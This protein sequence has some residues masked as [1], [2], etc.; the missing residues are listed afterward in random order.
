MNEPIQLNDVHSQLNLTPVLRLITIVE[1]ADIRHAIIQAKTDKEK[2]I[3]SGGRHAMGGQQFLTNG[4][5]L[6]FTTYNKIIEL[7]QESGI[8]TLQ[9]G[10]TW[11]NL[12]TELQRLQIDSTSAW[13]IIQKPTGADDLTLGGSLSANVHGRGLTLK[14]IVADVESFTL[15]KADGSTCI[16]SREENQELFRLVIGGYGLFGAISTIRLRLT[17]RQKLMRKVE[18]TTINQLIDKFYERI[19]QGHIYGDFQF[20]IDNSSIEFL[21]RGILASYVP[22]EEVISSPTS[23]NLSNEQWQRL[24]RLAHEEKS[25]AYDEYAEFYLS[26]DGQV[27]WSDVHQLSTYVEDYHQTVLP[28]APG[29]I[30][31]TE[32]ISEL[33]VPRSKLAEFM[34]RSTAIMRS[35]NASVIYGTIRLIEKD[36]ETFLPWAKDSFACIIFN[37]CTDHTE[38]GIAR[39]A[40]AFRD[41]I[42]AAIAE[43][44]SY[45]LTYHKFA[46]VSQLL[47]CYPQFPDFLV[48]KLQYDPEE[49]FTS[50][51]YRHYR[52]LLEKQ[53]D[54]MQ[55]DSSH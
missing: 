11:G 19:G 18:L 16:C 35:H 41:L 27:Y 21:E 38:E 37:L 32:I 54:N 52:T 14:P 51:W 42:D 53:D 15:I 9:S 10:I 36:D 28:P 13:S 3:A 31:A 17:R 23:F 2:I 1:E 39:S 43:G 6:D 26:T 34:K 12:I 24:L 7:D 47:T 48:K 33:Y 44:G 40:S 29:E 30:P 4:I 5:V 22:V 50:D 25:R 49:R 55:E 45:Y 8:V 20:D 46:T